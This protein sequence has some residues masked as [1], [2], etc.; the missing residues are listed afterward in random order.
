MPSAYPPAPPTLSGDILSINRLLMSPTQLTRR[1][2]TYVDLRFVS[3]QVLTG[4]YTTSGGAIGYELSEPFVSDRPVK[5]V[6]PGSTYPGANLPTGTAGLASVQKWGQKVRVTDE[7]IKRNSYQGQIIDRSLQKVV[8]TIIGQVDG[9]TM[10]AIASVVT[11]TSGAAFHWD[12]TGGSPPVILRDILLARKQVLGLN[13]GYKPDTL[14]V[15]DSAYA[16]MMSDDKV[17][18]AIRRETLDSPIY[19]GQ[20]EIIAGMVILVSPHASANPMVFDSKQ[21]GGMADED[22]TSPGYAISDLN[23]GVKTIR[24]EDADRFDLQ[25]RRLTVPV[26]QEPG[27]ACFITLT[28]LN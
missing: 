22:G 15:D 10:S 20:M 8:N 3:D 24:V 17:T 6:A 9:I 5:A 21:L 11:A 25:G 19:T 23:V 14:L 1:L 26:I 16:Y 2:R 27:A 18:N 13:L 7:E 4:R 28:G 12:G